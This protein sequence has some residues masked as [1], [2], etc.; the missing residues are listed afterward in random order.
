MAETFNEHAYTF[1]R[2]GLSYL[3][4]IKANTEKTIELQEQAICLQENALV[5]I[6]MANEHLDSIT[7]LGLETDDITK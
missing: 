7:D 2:D 1:Y 5:Q 3:A 4:E 6:K